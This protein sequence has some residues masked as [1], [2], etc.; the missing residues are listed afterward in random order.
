MTTDDEEL[1]RRIK[2]LRHHGQIVKNEHTELGYNYRLQAIQAAVLGVKLTYL[3]GWNEKRRALAERYHEGLKNTGYWMAAENKDCKPVYHLF[4]LGCK[5]QQVVGKALA[6]ADI[7]WGRH[8]PVPIHLQPAFLH[9][10]Y[11]RG[12]FP[13]S[14]KLMSTSITLPM[15]PELELD[16]VD[17]VCEVLR[18]ID[19][20]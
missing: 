6:D 14:E 19:Q 1:V 4:A 13:V 9:L 5:D 18:T 12:D 3:D 16:K 11:S 7:G 17:R 2:G 20:T 8:Y 10:S 15:F